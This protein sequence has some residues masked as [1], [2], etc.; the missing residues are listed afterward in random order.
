MNV[1]MK[2]P[3]VINNNFNQ[4]HKLNSCLYLIIWKKKT[5]LELYVQMSQER[6][7]MLCLGKEPVKGQ[8]ALMAKYLVSPAYRGS[9]V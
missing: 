3:F 5:A 2:P 4:K 1:V 6:Q 7:K 8:F 9:G